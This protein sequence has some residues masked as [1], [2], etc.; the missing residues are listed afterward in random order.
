MCRATGLATED[1]RG[2]ENKRGLFG[3][4][5]QWYVREE[6]RIQP[7]SV[8]QKFVLIPEDCSEQSSESSEFVTLIA[9]PQDFVQLSRMAPYLDDLIIPVAT[10]GAALIAGV[11]I[12]RLLVNYLYRYFRRRQWHTLRRLVRSFNGL[13]TL[14]FGLL[15]LRA[16]LPDLP[17]KPRYIPITQHLAS[18]LTILT[19]TILLSRVLIALVRSRSDETGAKITSISLIENI[20]KIVVYLIGL[21][22][23]FRTFGIAVTPILTALGVGGLAVA[24]A[25]QDTLSNLFAGIYIILSKNL[26]IGDYIKVDG[27][28]E[29]VIRDIA[30][31]VTTLETIGNTLVIIPN[32]KLST[33]VVVNYDKPDRHSDLVIPFTFDPHKTPAFQK[34]LERTAEMLRTRY[35]EE[36]LDIKIQYTS[37][38]VAHAAIDLVIRLKD[39]SLQNALRDEAIRAIIGAER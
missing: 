7:N 15:A 20:S 33:G 3:R 32:N 35:A 28:Q 34:E 24:L 12:E 9:Q 23:I 17:L 36:I 6:L 1:W 5:H 16:V 10:I 11:A 37:L 26:S 39:Y 13:V 2:L 14:W 18:A 27:A 21:L 8:R 4:I 25:L 31:R 38:T 30:W 29:G 22:F 19:V